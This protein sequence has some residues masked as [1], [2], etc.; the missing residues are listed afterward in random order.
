MVSVFTSGYVNTETILHFFILNQFIEIPYHTR[1]ERFRAQ[2]A[3]KKKERSALVPKL[4]IL[5][6]KCALQIVFAEYK[7]TLR[8][9]Q[10]FQYGYHIMKASM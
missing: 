5:I 3:N 8:S 2:I 9:N 1:Q 10:F 7:I 4:D 6:K